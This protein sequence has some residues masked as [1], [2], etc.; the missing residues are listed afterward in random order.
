[1]TPEIS[2]NQIRKSW[3]GAR[4]LWALM[5]PDP[6]APAE[7]ALVHL[8]ANFSFSQNVHCVTKSKGILCS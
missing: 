3:G 4:G 8:F 7:T 2:V 1:M 5:M 6:K